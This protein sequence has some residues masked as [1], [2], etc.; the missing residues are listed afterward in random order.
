MR[1]RSAPSNHRRWKWLALPWLVLVTALLVAA[2]SYAD[3]T[4]PDGDGAVPVSP[5][6]NPLDFG[7]V[8]VGTQ[9]QDTVLVAI[10]RNEVVPDASH[11]IQLDRPDVVIK[12]V[13][14][15]VDAVRTQDAATGYTRTSP[16]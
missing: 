6:L 16:R 12:A 15:V 3:D 4:T 10:K 2:A 8:C 14:E 5:A 7:N 11:Y 13:R 1:H 9:Y